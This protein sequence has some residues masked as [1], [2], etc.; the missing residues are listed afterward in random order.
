L[1]AKE[2]VQRLHQAKGATALL[3][4]LRGVE[5]WDRP[6][7]PLHDPEGLEAFTHA[8]RS[9]VTALNS[10]SFT[11]QEVDAHINDD[12]FCEAVLA[13]FDAWIELGIVVKP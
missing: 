13:Q 12:A 1:I 5:A 8:L 3:M 9:E 4:P 11:Y 10:P 7:E 6:G 2:M